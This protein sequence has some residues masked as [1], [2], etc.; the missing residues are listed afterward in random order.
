[1]VILQQVIKDQRDEIIACL[2][3]GHDGDSR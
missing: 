3:N 1:M 2:S